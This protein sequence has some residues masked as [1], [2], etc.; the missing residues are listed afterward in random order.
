MLIVLGG[1]PGTGKTT[2]GKA[3]AARRSATY[4]RVDDIEH[5]LAGQADRKAPIGAEGYAV[6]MA[7]AAANLALG[8]VVVADSVNPV[9]ES[10]Q[11]WRDAARVAQAP[12][13]EVEIVCSD[14]AE[15]RRRIE[16]RTADI[17]G[18]RLP[19]WE[20]VRSRQYAPWT[21]P[22]LIID[23]ARTGVSEAVAMIERAMDGLRAASAPTQ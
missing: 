19:T 21:E 4:L 12:V 5:V 13:L 8:N 7:I 15:H 11:G 20:E 17:P 10:R 2:I 3:L 16:S 1:L 22:R 23:S 9:P 18:F 14:E 6:A